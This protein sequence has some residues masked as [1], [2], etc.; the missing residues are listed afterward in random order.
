MI[1]DFR[2]EDWLPL[3]GGADQYSLS[4]IEH[5]HILKL[6]EES[7]KVIVAGL[8]EPSDETI[9]RLEHFHSKK[10]S[11]LTIDPASL[12][13]AIARMLSQTDSSQQAVFANATKIDS[14]GKEDAPIINLV[15]SLIIDGL[16]SDASDI[17][18]EGFHNGGMVRYRIDGVLETVRQMSTKDFEAVS[19]RIK[20]L[21][22]L[23]IMEKRLPQD[24]R[25][26]VE[27][28][29]IEIDFRVSI[30]PLSS[31]ESI[32][33]RIFRKEGVDL[34]LASLGF[35][36]EIENLLDE[37]ARHPH[38]LVL[39]TGP[40]GSG[41]T[42]TLSAVLKEIQDDSLKIITIEDPV[43][44]VLPGID[45][46]QVNEKIGLTFQSMLRRVLRQDP[47]VIMVGEI[48]DAETAELA[49]RA[50]LTGHLV[51]STLHTNDAVSAV[52]RLLDMGIE[53]YLLAG[54][55]RGVV[56]Q[57]LVRKLCVECKS[58]RKLSSSET[59]HFKKYGIAAP[60]AF[61]PEG[62]PNCSGSGY[63]GRIAVG[64]GFP[65]GV[66]LEELISRGARVEE[67]KSFLDK[68]GMESLYAN[69]LLKVAE[70]VT[71]LEELQRVIVQ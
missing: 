68:K 13:S 49:V 55:L 17:H 16:R 2:L 27:F 65:G 15:N 11:Y 63:R 50:A 6:K 4:F 22:N 35:T 37:T 14:A 24:G 30:V 64:E 39:I 66:Q 19:G 61:Q 43:E 46:I 21:S 67:L 71:S 33:L 20:V 34:E 48:R 57:R 3:P 47:N 29:G 32:V 45:Q 36:P 25:L 69:G 59:M 28:G 41:K 56:A 9:N 51:L 70:G 62:C 40:T 44:N 54:V 52:P 58:P 31:G 10:I 26:R 53:A 7:D 18:I 60:Q 8:E 1:T 42:T 5:N 38:G 12:S 23:N